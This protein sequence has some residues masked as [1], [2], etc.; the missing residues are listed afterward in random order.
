MCYT[1]LMVRKET[2]IK[3]N[4][5]PQLQVLD[6]ISGKWTILIV[7]ILSTDKKRY[8]E[9][10]RI[11]PG[12]SQKMLTQTLRKLERNGIVDRKVYPVVPPQVEYTLT[13]LGTSLVDLLS[14]IYTWGNEHYPQVEQ[15]CEEYDTR[16]EEKI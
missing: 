1:N 12:I 14:K 11:I 3:R 8:G 13:P 2:Q 7:H 15:A 10:F 16:L 6:T 5:P 4:C 9:L